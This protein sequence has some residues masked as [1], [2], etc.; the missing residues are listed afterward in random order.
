MALFKISDINYI[1]MPFGWDDTHDTGKVHCETKKDGEF[2]QAIC[3]FKSNIKNN[4]DVVTTFQVDLKRDFSS[5]IIGRFHYGDQSQTKNATFEIDYTNND[6]Y[7]IKGI[8][9]D[10]K[11][12]SFLSKVKM[13]DIY[14]EG[15][16]ISSQTPDI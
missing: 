11:N 9:N 5:K 3:A 16:Q 13:Q 8:Y 4:H 7:L 6:Y 1:F 14:L 2:H 10:K 12:Y 15:Y